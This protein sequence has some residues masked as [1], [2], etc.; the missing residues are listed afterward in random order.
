MTGTGDGEE[1][2]GREDGTAGQVSSTALARHNSGVSGGG[3]ADPLCGPP[4]AAL[5]L[6]LR[7]LLLPHATH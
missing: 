3:W 5:P 7:P 2:P 4:P 1:E 6:G